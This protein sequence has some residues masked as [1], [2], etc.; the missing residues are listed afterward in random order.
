M[1][2]LTRR[3][4]RSFLPDWNPTD[5]QIDLGIEVVR[6]WLLTDTGLNPLPDPLPSDLW[7]DAVEL[8]ALVVDNPTSYASTTT[9][10]TSKFWPIAARRDNIRSGIRRRYKMRPTGCY[11][12]AQGY[13]ERATQLEQ[14][15][16]M[17]H[18][19]WDYHGDWYWTSE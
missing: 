12:T 14:P 2:N 4:L 19:W 17:G 6:G 15:V 11:P 7:A 3:D 10:P 16:P 18:G 1:P 9:G 8:V 13:P 5:D